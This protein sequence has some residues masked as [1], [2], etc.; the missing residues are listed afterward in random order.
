[1]TKL[2]SQ[3]FP[4]LFAVLLMGFT[5]LIV[6]TVL[7]REFLVTFYGNELTIGLILANWLIL[8]SLGSSIFARFAGRNKRPIIFYVLLQIGVALYFPI[9]ILLAR[10][11]KNLFVVNLGEMV[12]II[13]IFLSSFFVML[14]LSFLDG[15]EFPFA[16]RLYSD[17][18]GETL[19]SAGK[20]Y[21][22]E[23][24]GFIIA[25]LIFTYLLLTHLHSAQI[26]FLV[27]FLNL[28]S[29]FFL[30]NVEKVRNLSKLVVKFAIIFFLLFS[31]YSLFFNFA[32][33]L[34]NF[35]ITQQWK[36]RNLIS[37]Q[38]T[39]YGNLSVIKE[40]E[41]YTF[42]S[43]GL[44]VIN[45]PYPDTIWVEE[46]VHFSLL[47]HS[48]PKNIFL[49]GG[50]AGGVLSE[51]LKHPVERIDYTELDPMLIK[52][53]EKYSTPLTKNELNNPRVKLIY[54][55][56]RRFVQTTGRKY[57]IILVNL[58]APATL[59][60][61][62]FYTVEFFRLIKEILNPKGIFVF[63]L[64]GSL[65]ALSNELRNLNGSMLN[66]LR[67]V[68][69]NVKIIPGE[70]N[71]FLS[72]LSRVEIGTKIFETR[73]K[74][75]K[76]KTK[77]LS[78]D[79]LNWRLDKKWFIWFE[80]SMGNFSKVGK[81]YDL[82]PKG[83]FYQLTY[84]NAFF[85]DNLRKFFQFLGRINF[86]YIFLLLLIFSIFLFSLLKVNPEYKKYIP[87]YAIMT[88]GFLGMTFN[89]IFIF[90]YQSF[91]GYVYHHLALLITAFMA[92]LTSGG[93]L[94]TKKLVQIKENIVSFIRIEFFLVIFSLILI[95]LLIFLN[96]SRSE[97]SFI[98]FILASMV[99]FLVGFE[100][101]LANKILQ[102][103]KK[104]LHPAGLVYASDLFG[105]WVGAL[106]ISVGL[107]P[108]IGVIQTILF[109][110]LLKV[111]SLTFLFIARS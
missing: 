94:M 3:K 70:N 47:S 11:A 32:E 108:I 38:N 99:G 93:W 61:N 54:T 97:I 31:I 17:F 41:Q 9:S 33:K 12:G 24:V 39:I 87:L 80:E 45:T 58:P 95:P 6:Q 73:L 1:M 63:S 65:S 5:S 56:G 71:L 15:I 55:D 51:I 100:F 96:R 83:L 101:P 86:F 106:I 34:Q 103:E 78:S 84:W 46:F 66:S 28:L 42:Y 107:I 20:V 60:L 85:S 69:S 23:A 77:L 22:L 76:I 50:G 57:D 18:S 30:L 98:F 43:D 8:E 35:S 89:L 110:V 104:L 68:F 10:I 44:P 53:V 111:S 109:L 82:L 26:A 92:G 81:N 4:L 16:C 105:A 7:L 102:E 79:Y 72:S 27:T 67:E 90:V 52:L 2:Q 13:P 21:I 62:R 49:V 75:R 48:K 14:P 19:E 37:S 74:E 36:G 29:A 40:R 59:Q 91:Y 88:T 25:G 64:P